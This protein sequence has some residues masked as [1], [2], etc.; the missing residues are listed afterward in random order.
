MFFTRL[1]R[2][3]KWMFVFL[4]LVF[5]LGFVVFGIGS[6]Q[7][8]GIGD[9]LRDQ[10]A[11]AGGLS[12]D[13]ARERVQDN[14]RNTE[15]QYDLAVALQEEGDTQ[16]AI[17]VLEKLVD[18]DPTHE[19]ALRDLAGLHL[20][21]ASTLSQAAQAEQI[22]AAFLAP[23]AQLANPLELGDSGATLSDPIQDAIT[24]QA[25]AAVN[26]AYGKAQEAYV[27]A[28]EAY[29]QLADARPNDPNV[30]LELAQAAQQSGD[31]T[32]AI[33]AYE[34]FLELAPDDPSAEIVREQLK[35]LKAS[36][37]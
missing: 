25:S 5:G 17:T 36:R 16:E 10:G 22:R 4:A 30:Q 34:Q 2:H 18:Q 7:G 35:Q 13:D 33:G 8:T 19:D 1:R 15:A 12:V 9:I 14:P 21:R 26:E 28:V 24:T 20:A 27:A 11:T 6:D 3:A 32:K 37:G 29:D 23:G 31:V